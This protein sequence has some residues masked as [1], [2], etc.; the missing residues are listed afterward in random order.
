MENDE[1]L[2]L[3]TDLVTLTKTNHVSEIQYLQHMNTKQT[4]QK[5]NSKSYVLLE[6]GEVKDFKKT[7]NRSEG[8][9]SL[10]KTFKKLRYLINNNFIGAQNELFVTLTF[11]PD[12]KGWRPTLGDNDYLALCFKNFIRKMKRKYG[13]I[14]FLRVV[15]PHADGHAHYHVLLRFDDH[16]KMYIHSSDLAKI[17]GEG[18]TVVHSLKNVD[19]IGAYVSAYLTDIELTEKTGMDECLSGH[20]TEVLE[21]EGKKYIK[22]GRM[23]YYPTGKQIYN[24]S[25]GIVEPVRK[26]MTYEKAK[27]IVGPGRPTYEKNINVENAEFTNKIRYENYN[28]LR[29]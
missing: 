4:I 26:R 18:F 8:L 29:L 10:Y 28:S 6:T 21:K 2:I 5:I 23:K 13:R 25:K 27:K 12:R 24:K 14:E 1:I 19:N 20:K 9:K 7:E 22:G 11:A 15:E 17:W 3:P 16:K